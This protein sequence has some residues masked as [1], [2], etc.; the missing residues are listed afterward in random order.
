MALLEQYK[1]HRDLLEE[2]RT[3]VRHA[4]D[5]DDECFVADDL[6]FSSMHPLSLH[7]Q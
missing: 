3:T 7:Q 2:S 6:A 1:V 5:D 4:D